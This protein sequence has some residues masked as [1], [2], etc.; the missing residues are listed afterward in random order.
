MAM[1][2]NGVLGAPTT[3][4]T[5]SGMT[6]RASAPNCPSCGAVSDTQG[7]IPRCPSHGTAPFERGRFLG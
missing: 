7:S 3:N 2:K 5:K 6:K 1:E 4:D